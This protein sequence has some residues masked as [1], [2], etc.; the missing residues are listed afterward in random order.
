MISH[1]SQPRKEIRR[2]RNQIRLDE[3]NG[4]E[5]SFTRADRG[6]GRGRKSKGMVAKVTEY[7][8]LPSDRSWNVTRGSLELFFA[9]LCAH[10]CPQRWACKVRFLYLIYFVMQSC[11]N[12][13]FGTSS[14][15][16][17]KLWQ[18]W[19]LPRLYPN[20]NLESR[21]IPGVT[22]LCTWGY[23][24]QSCTTYCS[25]FVIHEDFVETVH[26]WASSVWKF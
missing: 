17:P 4:I 11:L 13:R 1:A 16:A 20:F 10:C 6:L 9:R 19:I 15:R 5:Q 3:R 21:S 8:I 14:L 12:S 18:T 25:Y 24:D 23:Y 2:E 22:L 26:L 7:N